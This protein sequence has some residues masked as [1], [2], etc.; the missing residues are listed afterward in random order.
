[1]KARVAV[2]RTSPGQVLEDYARLMRSVGYTDVIPAANASYLKVNMGWQEWFPAASTSPWQLEGV[3]RTLEEDGYPPDTL[4]VAEG[5]VPGDRRQA[6]VKNGLAMAA[7]T[8]GAP[9]V[10]FFD[11][12][13]QWTPFQPR[14]DLAA[15][16]RLIGTGEILIPEELLGANI[17]HLPAARTDSRA[18]IGGAG[19]SALDTFMDGVDVS[20]ISS[21]T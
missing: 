7:A 16:E 4:R 12:E 18:V 2:L 1:M 19:L 6:E 8:R 21:K 11:S 13:V 3:L 5:F 17:I 10:H 15:I 14:A 9:F 20:P